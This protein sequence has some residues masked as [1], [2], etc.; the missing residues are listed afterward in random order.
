MKRTIVLGDIHA[1]GDKLEKALLHVGAI[2]A[3]G[4]KN[5]DVHVIANGDFLNFGYGSKEADF[6]ARWFGMVDHANLGNHEGAAIGAPVHNGYE[7][8]D[9]DCERMFREDY[10]NGRWQIAT[11]V[12]GW[13]VTH[14]GIHPEYLEE[15]FPGERDV[16]V[17]AEGLNDLYFDTL[18]SDNRND[19]HPVFYQMCKWR[20]GWGTRAWPQFDT[21]PPKGGVLWLDA[22]EWDGITSPVPQIIGHSPQEHP[23]YLQSNLIAI[24]VYGGVGFAYTDDDG[25]TWELGIIPPD[26]KDGDLRGDYYSTDTKTHNFSDDLDGWPSEELCPECQSSMLEDADCLVCTGCGG[27]WQ[28]YTDDPEADA[29]TSA[30]D[31]QWPTDREEA[32]RLMEELMAEM[33]Y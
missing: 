17:I 30:A 5:P 31:D 6:Y 3:N 19:L 2:D 29:L 18:T 33:P 26:P 28:E 23:R 11:A 9:L 20:S 1:E 27:R 24:D 10:R 12:G 32:A 21:N 8:R 4:N 22:K 14:A 16:A 7:A 25:E 15:L 13:L